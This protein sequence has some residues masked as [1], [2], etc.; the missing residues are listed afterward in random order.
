[1]RQ[2]V[3]PDRLLGRVNATQRFLVYGAIPL[4][5]LLGGALGELIGVPMTLVVG[6]LGMLLASLWLLLSPVRSM[7]P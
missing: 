5:G 2:A 1:M 7:R 3:T 6:M 4:G